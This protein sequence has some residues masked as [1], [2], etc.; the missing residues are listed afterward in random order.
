MLLASTTSQ[1]VFS[2]GASVGDKID[3][4]RRAHEIAA[5]AYFVVGPSATHAL[6]SF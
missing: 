3:S 1:N 2:N 5:A 6:E 4:I